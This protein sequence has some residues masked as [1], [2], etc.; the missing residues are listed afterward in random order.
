MTHT[1]KRLHAGKGIMGTIQPTCSCGWQGQAIP[2][3]N[4][5]QHT[6]VKEQE[7]EHLYAVEKR[8]TIKANL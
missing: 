4:D 5:W 8:D 6:I 2:A 1:L 7:Q 3:H